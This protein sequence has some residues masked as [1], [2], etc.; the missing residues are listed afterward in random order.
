MTK[1]PFRAAALLFLGFCGTG[2]F[3]LWGTRHL[4]R[5]TE[6]APNRVTSPASVEA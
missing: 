4:D 6:L 2:F 5:D 3:W 1:S